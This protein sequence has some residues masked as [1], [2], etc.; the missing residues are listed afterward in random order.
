MR[1]GNRYAPLWDMLGLVNETPASKQLK[2]PESSSH[3]ETVAASETTN[4]QLKRFGLCTHATN[5]W[6]SCSLL[7]LIMD[8]IYLYIAST[9]SHTFTN[10][11]AGVLL[12]EIIPTST[13]TCMCASPKVRS[14][15][16]AHVIICRCPGAGLRRRCALSRL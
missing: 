3:F 14:S 2:L 16:C 8:E 7:F 10:E 13:H 4:E 15:I 1:P 11:S 9:S 6:S 12:L 5:Q